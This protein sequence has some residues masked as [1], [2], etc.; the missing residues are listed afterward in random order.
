MNKNN[1]ELVTPEEI[2]QDN[3]EDIKKL[4]DLDSEVQKIGEELLKGIKSE[5]DSLP[6]LVH[7]K[8]KINGA[9]EIFSTFSGS[10]SRYG[11][12][13]KVLRIHY[14]QILIFIISTLEN[15]LTGYFS[16][17]LRSNYT[18]LKYETESIGKLKVNLKQIADSDFDFGELLF[19]YIKDIDQSISFQDLKSTINTFKKYFGVKI[20]LTK[21]EKDDLIYYF[22]CRHSIIHCNGIVDAKFIKQ[23]HSTE[24]SYINIG[25]TIEINK[26]DVERALQLIIVFHDKIVKYCRAKSFIDEDEL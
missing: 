18:K 12:F 11:E 1:Q 10:L 2:F 23:I 19:G 5:A 3:I 4:I 20:E 17:L 14:R 7:L 26:E 9:L 6:S 8:Q 21:K 15:F 13:Y 24:Y 22:A 16:N 25:Y